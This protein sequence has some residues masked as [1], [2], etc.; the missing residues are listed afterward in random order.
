MNNYNDNKKYDYFYFYRII[1]N[2]N[3]KTE[4]KNHANI[5]MKKNGLKFGL[6]NFYKNNKEGIIENNKWSWINSVNTHSYCFYELYHS[7]TDEQ[8]K[9]LDFDNNIIYSIGKFWEYIDEKFELYFTKNITNKYYDILNF[10]TSQ[11]WSKGII[12]NIFFIFSLK[13]IFGDDLVEKSYSFER[14]D[15]IDFKGIDFIVELKNNVFKTFQ[16]KSGKH[17]YDGDHYLIDSS[18][19]DLK[20][21][22]DYYCYFDISNFTSATNILIFKNEKEKIFKKDGFVL[23][24]KELLYK[25]FVNTMKVPQALKNTLWFCG[26]RKINFELNLDSEEN[27]VIIYPK[28][29]K[30]IIININNIYDEDL[31][32][33]LENKLMELCNIFQ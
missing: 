33:L 22:A 28:E 15:N 6:W 31:G 1:S 26:P 13:T 10:R 17:Y 12:T 19:N 32:D 9:S 20:S 8:K 30:K 5:V 11:S 18:L 23:F 21:P 29:E 14:G 2:F 24:P 27:N 4:Y 7:L 25:Y 3:F 16:L